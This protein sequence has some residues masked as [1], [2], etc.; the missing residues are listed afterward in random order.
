MRQTAINLVKSYTPMIKFV[1]TKHQ[2]TQHSA[3]IIVHPCTINGLLPGSK[4]SLGVSEYLGKIKPFVVI[5]YNN[6]NT[7][8]NLQGSSNLKYQ[9]TNRPL[10]KDELSSMSQLPAKFRFR[11]I[12]DL[13]LETINSGGAH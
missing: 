3:E 7:T 9:F 5:P 8:A 4:E 2:V 6:P 13:E 12:D 10:V 1:G 11:P